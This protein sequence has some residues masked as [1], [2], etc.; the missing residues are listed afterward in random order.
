MRVVFD[1]VRVAVDDG[2]LRRA[3]LTGGDGIL[4][5]HIHRV[6]APHRP[7]VE[8]HAVGRAGAV[9]PVGLGQRGAQPL[10]AVD[11]PHAV[12]GGIDQRLGAG[13]RGRR[14]ADDIQLLGVDHLPVVEVRVRHAEALAESPQPFGAAV[15]YGYNFRLGDRLVG[16]E[17]P[18]GFSPVANR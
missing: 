11:A 14:H 1:D 15:R 9:D 2:K 12:L 18:V 8:R 6:M 10:F 16:A 4:H 7:P 13:E 5:G 3:D 17:V